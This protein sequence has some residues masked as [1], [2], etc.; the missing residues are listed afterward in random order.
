MEEDN[1]RADE[2]IDLKEWKE[3]LSLAFREICEKGPSIGLRSK[4]YVL[5]KPSEI[6]QWLMEPQIFLAGP[7]YNYGYIKNMP[8]WECDKRSRVRRKFRSNQIKRLWDICNNSAT[9][10]I[11]GIYP[12]I[13]R[14]WHIYCEANGMDKSIPT[15]TKQTKYETERHMEKLLQ[16]YPTLKQELPGQHVRKR[17]RSASSMRS[18]RSVTPR[19]ESH[20]SVSVNYKGKHPWTKSEKKAKYAKTS[21]G[22]H[23]LTPLMM[24]EALRKQSAGPQK[25]VY[26][27]KEHYTP[28]K[29]TFK[30][31]DW[32]DSFR[33]ILSEELKRDHLKL[34]LINNEQYLLSGTHDQYVMNKFVITGTTITEPVVTVPWSSLHELLMQI[35]ANPKSH[36][37]DARMEWSYGLT[38]RDGYPSWEKNASQT[39]GYWNMKKLMEKINENLS[40]SELKHNISTVEETVEYDTPIHDSEEQVKKVA[41]LKQICITTDTA[42]EKSPETYIPKGRGIRPQMFHMTDDELR[43]CASGSKEG[44]SIWKHQQATT[45]HQNENV[46]NFDSGNE[47][48]IIHTRL[49]LEKMHHAKQ[50]LRPDESYKLREIVTKAGPLLTFPCAIQLSPNQAEKIRV[51]K[52]RIPPVEQEQED[53]DVSNENESQP[54]NVNIPL[55][56]DETFMEDKTVR[57]NAHSEVHIVESH[58]NI[59]NTT[60]GP[61]TS[62]WADTAAGKLNSMAEQAKTYDAWIAHNP[63][64]E[65]VKLLRQRNIDSLA[66]QLADTTVKSNKQA[67]KAGE[68]ILKRGTCGAEIKPV[69]L[70]T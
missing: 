18:A 32:I 53:M 15:A 54:I 10:D 9:A 43:L 62:N 7:E 40:N 55:Q 2:I 52:I 66:Q 67:S 21:P 68:L 17:H 58:T 44:S 36:G 6:K 31:P 48:E 30:K 70:C 63:F 38:V 34:I 26:A 23:T 49:G 46:R 41:Q 65:S 33:P 12:D 60:F 20:S 37:D 50:N 42:K 61:T 11:L 69:Q 13:Q 5:A 3:A 39:N 25:K 8:K 24:A 4:V 1:A 22:T 57:R 59:G 35:N 28:T 45:S 64:P 16:L 27:E 56:G 47:L 51:D 14:A 29:D 19:D